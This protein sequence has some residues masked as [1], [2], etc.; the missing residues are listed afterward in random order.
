MAKEVKDVNEG[1]IAKECPSSL[2][3]EGYENSKSRSL[4]PTVNELLAALKT[5]E[6]DKE[7]SYIKNEWQHYQGLS[8]ENLLRHDG[9]RR[10]RHMVFSE[11]NHE[12]F[13]N[14][15]K[16]VEELTPEDLKI[17]GNIFNNLKA[18]N[19]SEVGKELLKL[20]LDP[21]NPD[22]SID[23]WTNIL[24]LNLKRTG[25]VNRLEFSPNHESKTWNL[26][27]KQTGN[28]YNLGY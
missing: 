24:Q 15:K 8:T 21:K 27:D 22:R 10:Y 9:T 3:K 20:R 25:L 14:T 26:E 17:I 11:M 19:F 12:Q 6:K 1:E 13:E 5:A 18:E 23:N 16:A 7:I 4:E 28:D 2:L